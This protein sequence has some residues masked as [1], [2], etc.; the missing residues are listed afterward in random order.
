MIGDFLHWIQSGLQSVGA[1]IVIRFREE[2]VLTLAVLQA[3]AAMAVGFGLG[4]SGEQVALFTTFMAA[5][6]GWVA[7]REVTPNVHVV[8]GE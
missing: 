5:L 2:P 3:G 1:G 8:E 7:R 4:W 6:L